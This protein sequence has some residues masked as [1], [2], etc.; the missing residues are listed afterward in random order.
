MRKCYENNYIS[1]NGEIIDMFS[2][3]QKKKL[4]KSNI[5]TQNAKDENKSDEQN[6][7]DELISQV[8]QLSKNIEKLE[9]NNSKNKIKTFTELFSFVLLLFTSFG[10]AFVYLNGQ[11]S[12]VNKNIDNCLTEEDIKDLRKSVSDIELWIKGDINDSNHKGANERLNKIEEKLNISPIDITKSAMS[13]IITNSVNTENVMSSPPSTE[14]YTLTTYVGEDSDGNKYNIGDIVNETV[15]L[16]YKENDNEVY[17][18]GQINENF[19]WN[20]YCVTN[21]YNKDGTLYGICESNFDDGKR[22]DYESIYLSKNENEWVHTKRTCEGEKNSGI[23]EI[24]NLEYNKTKNFTNT[25]VRVYDFLYSKDFIENNNKILISYYNGY[26]SNGEYNDDTGE[27]YL[28]KYFMPEDIQTTTNKPIIKLLYQGKFVRGE[29]SDEEY[30]SWSISREIN[31]TYMFYKGGF[32]DG[33]AN[34]RNKDKEEFENYLTH[35]RIVEYL[36]KY[37]FDKYSDNFITEYDE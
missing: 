35:D 20:G 5:Y 12:E 1:Y 15:L 24:F 18:L 25:N 22:I 9:K 31:T 3:L 28:I 13:D 7:I 33:K 27:A 37:G 14:K 17:F 16:T 21:I 30:N 36:H 26:T 32:S 34:S 23:T 29:P 8:D 2:F 11:F 6:K 19:H 10:G 4:I